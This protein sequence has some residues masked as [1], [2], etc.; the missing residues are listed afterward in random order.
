M[1]YMHAPN[2]GPPYHYREYQR[3]NGY[4][5]Y[6]YYKTDP[7]LTNHLVSTEYIERISQSIKMHNKPTG[8]QEHPAKS[9]RDLKLAYPD[10]QDG[11]YYIDP[12][13]GSKADAFTAN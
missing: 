11:T 1:G 10:T 7:A 9:C 8:T 4:G 2:K 13:R 5:G 3:F 12:N 6:A